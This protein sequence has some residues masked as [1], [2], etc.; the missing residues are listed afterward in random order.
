M[1]SNQDQPGVVEIVERT[2]TLQGAVCFEY[3]G[4][5][6]G[7]YGVSAQ[8]REVQKPADQALH[9]RCLVFLGGFERNSKIKLD[10]GDPEGISNST[11]SLGTCDF[12]CLVHFSEL[13][14]LKFCRSPKPVLILPYGPMFSLA[15]CSA[16]IYI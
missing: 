1:I 7:F 15:T 4:I 12:I 10:R 11:S 8:C 3:F 14:K 16:N 2:R 9:C 13:A 5:F 6:A